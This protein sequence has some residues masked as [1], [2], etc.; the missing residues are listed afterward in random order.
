MR[1]ETD[2]CVSE[3]LTIF[4]ASMPPG[5]GALDPVN[6]ILRDFGG[7]G[8]VIVECYGAAWAAWFGA[9]G[10]R[11]LRA[12]LADCSEHYLAD[13]L[14][15]QTVRQPKKR[16][17]AYVVHVARAVVDAMKDCHDPS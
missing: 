9:I 11:S 5:K 13:K 6:V 2:I 8:Q 10:S 12:F 4:D 16:E 1:I 17:E 3:A 14:V 15:C 7:S